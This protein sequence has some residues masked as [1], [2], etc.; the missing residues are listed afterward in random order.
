MI[1]FKDTQFNN[2]KD[3]IDNEKW[4]RLP[5]PDNYEVK[6]FKELMVDYPDEFKHNIRI[7]ENHFSGELSNF[8]PGDIFV[9]FANGNPFENDNMTGQNST[10]KT[11][12]IRSTFSKSNPFKSPFSD[13]EEMKEENLDEEIDVGLT[14]HKSLSSVDTKNHSELFYQQMNAVSQNI[15]ISSSGLNLVKSFFKYVELLN[16]L[17]PYSFEILLGLTQVFEFYIFSVFFLYSEESDQK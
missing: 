15:I 17:S 10:T 9:Q 16:V 12:N 6:E 13:D 5:L 4:E 7:F 2:L 3:F 14:I 8:S 11:Q 1:D